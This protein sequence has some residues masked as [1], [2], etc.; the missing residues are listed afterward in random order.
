M[1]QLL[2]VTVLMVLLVACGTA[3]EPEQV[4]QVD[5]VEEVAETAATAEP[6]ALPTDVPPTDIPIP[7][8]TLAPTDE[9][10]TPEPTDPPTEIPTDV[11]TEEP[12]E[13][14]AALPPTEIP[15]ESPTDIPPTD[16]PPTPVPPTAVP[17]DIPPTA[18]PT[19]VPPTPEPTSVPPT[20]PPAVNTSLPLWQTA[21]LVDAKTGATFTLADYVGET[22]FVEPMA[23]WC[24][25][26]RNQLGQVSTAMNTVGWGNA[27][28]V[29][30]SVETNLTQAQMA[31]YADSTQLPFQFAVMTPDVLRA[32]VA[33]FGSS[34]TASPSTPHF[35][36][37]ADGTTTA[38]QTGFESADDIAAEILSTQ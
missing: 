13:E 28:I 23:T 12:T 37:K 30:L 3:S 22:V 21:P 11:P 2:Y 33:Q 32:M 19:D 7:T 9:P 1:K 25:N 16:V 34:I 36:I 14:P 31:Q 35:I 6:T 27:R 38:L 24:T 4:E 18:V 26:C 17:T 5:A 20:E 15:T 29:V 10:A 8:P